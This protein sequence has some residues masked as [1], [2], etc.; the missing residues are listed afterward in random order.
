MPQLGRVCLT[1]CVGAALHSHSQPLYCDTHGSPKFLTEQK[2]LP[3]TYL[4][5]FVRVCVVGFG[6]QREMVYDVRSLHGEM[7]DNRSVESL[8]EQKRPEEA[9]QPRN[10]IP[11]TMNKSAHG[12][13][14]QREPHQGKDSHAGE[15]RHPGARHPGPHTLMDKSRWCHCR[16]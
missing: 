6:A 10:L 13:T 7:N 4:L 1:N 16:T 14:E 8:T 12:F 9:Y 11:R 15:S 2:I 5:S 3:F